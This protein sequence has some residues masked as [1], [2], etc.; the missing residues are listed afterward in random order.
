MVVMG[1]GRGVGVDAA[2]AVVVAAAGRVNARA[3]ASGRGRVASM[4]ASWAA[5]RATESDRA[6]SVLAS[7]AS[8]CARPEPTSTHRECE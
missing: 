1:R 6:A 4:A 7:D 8:S 5:R 2:A 3:G